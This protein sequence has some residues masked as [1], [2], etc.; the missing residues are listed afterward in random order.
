[1][2]DTVRRDAVIEHLHDVRAFHLRGRGRLAR[3]TV[4]RLGIR[5]EFDRD[6]L[7]D[8]L[9][10]QREVIRDPHASHSPPAE[11]G[12]ETD[13]WRNVGP[14]LRLSHRAK[15]QPKR[16]RE[17]ATLYSLFGGGNRVLATNMCQV[18]SEFFVNAR[19]G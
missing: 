16:P 1:E 15:T 2:G 6:E 12:D 17:R 7:D 14:W 13:R 19:D 5:C 4:E 3:E 10:A 8:D 18:V 11:A 9:R